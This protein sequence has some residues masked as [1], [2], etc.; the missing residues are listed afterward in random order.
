[1]VN[2]AEKFCLTKTC[3]KTLEPLF[4]QYN[5]VLAADQNNAKCKKVLNIS[6]NPPC[7]FAMKNNSH[8]KTEP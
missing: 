3:N 7:S 4:Q 8:S 1:M 6:I 2:G 5:L